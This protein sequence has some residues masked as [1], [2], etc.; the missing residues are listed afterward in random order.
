[1]TSSRSLALVVLASC[2][3]AQQPAPRSQPLSNQ[4][5]VPAAPPA[6]GPQFVRGEIRVH[7]MARER[8]TMGA[9][10][11]VIIK[12]ADASGQ[13]T[14]LPIAV[15][16]LEW[17]DPLPFE[18]TEL[19]ALVGIEDDKPWGDV[20]VTARHDQDGDAMSKEPGDITGSTRVR[21]PADGVIVL[22]DDV[23]P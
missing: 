12:R 23:I 15:D 3:G 8:V 22:L 6:D 11:F 10:V 16:K 7:P 20:V 19:N 13:P 9:T 1:M 21:A 5:S 2:G 18:L 17:A 14:G 4:Q